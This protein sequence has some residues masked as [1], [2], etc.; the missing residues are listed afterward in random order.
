MLIEKQAVV[1]DKSTF[2]AKNNVIVDQ[3]SCLG[4]QL[5]SATKSLLS[6]LVD[7]YPV[8]RADNQIAQ[9]AQGACADHHRRE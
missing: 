7:E 8:M 1:I 3:I 5:C 9:I 4:K 6:A 2:P